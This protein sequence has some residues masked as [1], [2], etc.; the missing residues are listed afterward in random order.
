MTSDPF[1]LT[2]TAEVGQGSQKLGFSITKQKPHALSSRWATLVNAGGKKEREKKKTYHKSSAGPARRR[3]RDGFFRKAPLECD[4][5]CTC[6]W[7]CTR[8]GFLRFDPSPVPQKQDDRDR[9]GGRWR[10][11]GSQ[12]T[13]NGLINQCLPW[14]R[15]D[16]AG[17]GGVMG[18]GRRRNSR[19]TPET[20]VFL[21]DVRWSTSTQRFVLKGGLVHQ[22]LS[23]CASLQWRVAYALWAACIKNA[24]AC[25]H[26]RLAKH[27]VPFSTCLATFSY[28]LF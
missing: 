5:P 22:L 26:E 25:A 15:C 11:R 18:V 10:G 14:V 7:C 16:A 8:I 27:S 21:K 9:E 20:P 1:R 28:Q 19:G 4:L 6:V 17:W 3:A 23:V 24:H 12:S 2:Q 13:L